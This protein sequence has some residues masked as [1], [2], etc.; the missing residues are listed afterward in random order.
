M[1]KSPIHD[2]LERDQRERGVRSSTVEVLGGGSGGGHRGFGGEDMLTGSVDWGKR[3]V[4]S[5]GDR[6]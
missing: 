4:K 5:S 3:V 2:L 6:R 1:N